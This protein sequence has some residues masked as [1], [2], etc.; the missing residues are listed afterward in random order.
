MRE[1]TTGFARC[2]RTCVLWLLALMMCACGGGGG[3]DSPSSTGP[4]TGTTPSGVP[5]ITANVMTFQVESVPAPVLAAGGNSLLVVNV[6]DAQSA[7]PFTTATVAANGVSLPYV[8]SLK[9]YRGW[10]ILS[11]GNSVTL[12]A[13]VGQTVYQVVGNVPPS[14]PQIQSPR[15]P[16]I[17][18]FMVHFDRSKDEFVSWN[19]ELPNANFHYAVA[20]LNETGDLVWPANGSLENPVAGKSISIPAASIPPTFPF[21]ATGTA[22]SLN[23]A[24]AASGSTLTMGAFSNSMIYAA[25]TEPALTLTSLAITPSPVSMSMQKQV[26][27]AVVGRLVEQNTS[28]QFQDLTNRVAW[29]SSA[30]GIASVTAT[31]LLTSVSS[32]VA[33][34][35]AQLNGVSTTQTVTVFQ[36]GAVPLAGDAYAYQINASHSGNTT[37]PTP[38]VFPNAAAWSV[39]LPQS[40][41][42]PIITTSSVYVLATQGTTAGNAG[43]AMYA[44]DVTT[45]NL[46]WGPVV[47]TTNPGV[48]FAYGQGRLI[49]VHRS[50]MAKGFDA[51][52]GNQAWTLDL[53]N[54]SVSQCGSVPTVYRG[55][56]Y[57]VGSGV[58]STVFAMDIATGKLLWSTKILGS[59]TAPAVTDDG[60]YVSGH[61]Q[62]YKLDPYSGVPLWHYV[63]AGYGGGQFTT[64]LYGNQLYMRDFGGA[65]NLIFDSQ[66]SITTGAYVS[67][68]I[69]TFGNGAVYYLDSTHTL[70]AQRLADRVG[71]W[72]LQ[73]PGS[74]VT[75]PIVVNNV[76]IT[77]TAS[78]MVKAY[79]GSNGNLV[80]SAAAGAPLVS[81][82]EVDLA[83]PLTGIA[84]G[85]GVLAV[86]ASNV[87]SVFRLTG[88]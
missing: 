41:S 12:S 39:T 73:E 85:H 86:A 40:V 29:S 16:T 61:L 47:L 71:L 30:P 84:A 11:S 21:I 2:S 15:T 38:L 46:Q 4:V 72:S 19:G 9:A 42:Y 1:D 80:W 20:V 77:G 43:A 83:P 14:Y 25:G 27:L 48:N 50:C 67:S 53:T 64:A 13:T 52:T 32:G 68:T 70:K 74:L 5:R 81:P 62:A 78:G 23:I 22:Q 49:T 88:P 79:D 31:G 65:P 58:E 10:L 59:G 66:T 24:G 33:T 18:V 34:I 56:A 36:P 54:T 60:V 3:G 6:V 37:F 51:T 63:G 7:A 87:L 76:V 8:A 69:P 35:T 57:A 26:Q 55:I 45:G 28:A 17:D 44:F 82:D 75:A